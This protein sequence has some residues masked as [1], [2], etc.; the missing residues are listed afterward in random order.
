M[1]KKTGLIAIAIIVLAVVFIAGGCLY[2]VREDEFG[3]VTKFG[4][5]VA[6]QEGAGLHF[7]LPFVEQVR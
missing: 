3:I 7:K 4:K 1:K 5:I 2:T 6:V